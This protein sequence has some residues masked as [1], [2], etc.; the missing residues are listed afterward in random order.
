M[1][2]G[3]LA[4]AREHARK[5]G[6]TFN[7]LVRDLLAKEIAPDPGART[8]AMFELADRLNRKSVDGPMSRDEAH[9]RG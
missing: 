5:S 2:E 6:T 3:L 9:M 8:R 7:Q 1:D 4:R